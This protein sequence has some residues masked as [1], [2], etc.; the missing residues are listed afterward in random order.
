M[1]NN[2]KYSM[3]DIMASAEELPFV[4]GTWEIILTFNEIRCVRNAERGGR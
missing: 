1:G 4:G 2:M 3:Q